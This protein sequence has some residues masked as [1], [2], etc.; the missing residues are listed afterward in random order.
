MAQRLPA[1]RQ[2]AAEAESSNIRFQV[3]DQRSEVSPKEPVG[4]IRLGRARDQ[5][6]YPGRGVLAGP[7][8]GYCD[9][10]FFSENDSSGKNYTLK[11]VY[12]KGKRGN[13]R[14]RPA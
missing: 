6:R 2:G 7:C 3:S 9:D 12:E 11:K 4:E 10:K 1:G 5:I 13:I 8:Q 14:D